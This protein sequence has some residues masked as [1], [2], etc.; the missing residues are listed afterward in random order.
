MSEERSFKISA[1]GGF[2]R[3]DVIEYIE[4]LL[5]QLEEERAENRRKDERIEDL[6]RKLEQYEQA[7]SETLDGA[8]ELTQ[9]DDMYAQI[10]AI[11]TKY[12]GKEE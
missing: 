9:T 2:N 6:E 11:L 3:K 10:D 5:S 12:L 1:V 4:Q 8:D 7:F